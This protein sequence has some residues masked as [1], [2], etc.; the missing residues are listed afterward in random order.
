MIACRHSNLK[1]VDLLINHSPGLIFVSEDQNSLS[2]LHVSTS[3]GDK[4]IV[5]SMLDAVQGLYEKGTTHR[6][7]NLTD[8]IGRTPFYNACYHGQLPIVKAFLEFKAKYPDKIDINAEEKSRRSPLHAAVSAPKFSREIVELLVREGELKLN[9]EAYPSSRSHKYISKILERKRS[10]TALPSPSLTYSYRTYTSFDQLE[11]D[12]PSSY[13]DDRGCDTPISA[14]S[15]IS[16]DLDAEIGITKRDSLPHTP[17]S[18]LMHSIALPSPT[19]PFSPPSSQIRIIC[20]NNGKLEAIEGSGESHTPFSKLLLTPLAEACVFNSQDIVEILINHGAKDL[21]GYGCQIAYLIH[22]PS[23]MYLILSHQCKLCEQ[24]EDKPHPH[25]L[26][27]LD[28]KEKHLKYVKGE[29]LFSELYSIDLDVSPFNLMCQPV[30]FNRLE[31]AS[32]HI[33]HLQ[34]NGLQTLPIELFQLPNVTEINVAGNS[35][36]SLPDIE[37]DSCTV[38]IGTNAWKC[39]Q[40]SVLILSSNNLSCLPTCLWFLPS[41]EVLKASMNKL[42]SL[43]PLPKALNSLLEKDDSIVLAPDLREI[44]VSKNSLKEVDDF[45]FS[46][47]QLSKLNLSQ[48]D[49][50]S[51]PPSLWDCLTL[52]QLDVSSNSLSS[53]P[54]CGQQEDIREA[55]IAKSTPGI[56]HMATTLSSPQAVFQN[57][58]DSRESLHWVSRRRRSKSLKSR[59]KKR[60]DEFKI[61]KLKEEVDSG[62]GGDVVIE[63]CDYSV[64]SRLN[65][66]KNRFKSFPIGLPCLAP[67]LCDLDISDNNIQVIDVVFLPQILRKLSAKRCSLEKFGNTLTEGQLSSM[68]R[69]CYHDLKSNICL[70][71]SHSQLQ[72]LQTFML[73]DNRLKR[74]QLLKAVLKRTTKDPTEDE[75]E[76]RQ[77]CSALNLLYPSMEGLDLTNNCLVGTFNPNIGRQTQLKWLWLSHNKELEKLP[78]HLADLKNFRRLTEIKLKNLPNLVEPPKEYQNES[79]QASQLLT[80]MRSR[81]KE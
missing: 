59:T 28:W 37:S 47:S 20:S 17:I 54:R 19:V 69:K 4:G 34:K 21:N 70:H 2:P 60:D 14:S 58:L 45:V 77:N 11:S 43:V 64:L 12:D 1:I 24:I 38:S 46:L 81:L 57:D 44:D 16:D 75:L 39:S 72:Y 23:L 18:P 80:Y 35:L 51:L 29:W 3:R 50:Q 56:L 27:T 49:L 42:E 62:E 79:V 7:L 13:R 74:F 73:E 8:K 6:D 33:V 66:S 10:L 32:I 31:P 15:A 68:R 78:L 48:N 30:T 9:I 36:T 61:H 22:Q 40:L 76:F 41:L 5:Q 25:P 63:M 52:H 55:A 65:L 26:Y 53:L 71:C 67:N